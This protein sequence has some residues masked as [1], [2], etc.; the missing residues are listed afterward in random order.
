MEIPSQFAAKLLD[1]LRRREREVLGLHYFEQFDVPE[2]A[3]ML[4][5]KADS[6][7]GHLSKGVKVASDILGSTTDDARD[8]FASMGEVL[9]RRHPPQTIRVSHGSKSVEI[10]VLTHR[11]IMSCAVRDDHQPSDVTRYFILHHAHRRP[12]RHRRAS[13]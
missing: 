4:S 7:S 8:V 11:Q 10:D 5:V 3:C 9:A 13:R 6:V 2:I 12:H 1:G